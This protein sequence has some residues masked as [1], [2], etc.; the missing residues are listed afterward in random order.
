LNFEVKSKIG[1]LLHFN[2]QCWTFDVRCSRSVGSDPAAA[3]ETEGTQRS[4]EG[5][6]RLR[7]CSSQLETIGGW[8]CG[9]NKNRSSDSDAITSE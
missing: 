7:H 5:G 9:T 8:A 3:K 1:L 2:V 6:G 4:Q